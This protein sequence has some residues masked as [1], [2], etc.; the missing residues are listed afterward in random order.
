MRKWIVLVTIAVLAMAFITGCKDDST[1]PEMTAFEILTNYL[2]ANG[3]SMAN[4]FD[5][6]IVGADAVVDSANYSI[7]DYYVMDIR[8]GDGD[9]DGI[10]DFDEGHIP[11]AVNSSLGSIV[12]DAAQADKPI[13]VV[14]YTGQSAGHAVMALRLSGYTDAKVLK[15]GM[16]GWHSDFDKWT[17]NVAQL[18]HANWVAAPGAITTA[19]VF[20]YPDWD[21]DTTDGA[22]ILAA[23]VDALLEGGFKGVKALDTDTV[24][25][26]LDHPEDYFINNYWAAEDV[27]TYGNIEGAYRI[28]PLVLENLDPN[29]TIVTYCWTGQ[30]SS[31]VT[32][33]LTLLG[34][35]AKSLTFG[36]NSI[37]YDD[38]LGHKWGAAMDY[39]YEVTE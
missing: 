3:M 26:A 34:Y 19:E 7:P 10:S 12:D 38:L 5:G 16:S 9:D 8:T 21:I 11:N 30:T 36:V 31:M 2:D 37:I 15:W 23:R 4:L 1:D 17:P 20:G 14:C 35:D 28:N 39:P 29:S 22:D 18:D 32:A 27:E 25:G 6:W 33:Y 24:N 13:L